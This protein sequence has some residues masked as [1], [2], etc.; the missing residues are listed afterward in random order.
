MFRAFT[1]SRLVFTA[2]AASVALGLGVAL[3]RVNAGE[4]TISPVV[5]SD[6]ASPERLAAERVLG[7]LGY[8]DAEGVRRRGEFV[9][10]EATDRF[11]VRRRLVLSLSEGTVVGEQA[12]PRAAR[13]E[14]R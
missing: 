10:V 7:R 6:Q 12:L 11:G 9:V 1:R 5:H 13:D 2:A 8:R 14:S 3:S 4:P